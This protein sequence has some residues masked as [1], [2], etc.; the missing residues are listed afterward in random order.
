M[1]NNFSAHKS[2]QLENSFPTS[3]NTLVMKVIKREKQRGH[4]EDREIMPKIL[5]TSLAPLAH[6]LR[7]DQNIQYA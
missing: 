1:N 3:H 5:A 6:T 2:A 4:K 7:S